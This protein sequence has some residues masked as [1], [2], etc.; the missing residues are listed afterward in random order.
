MIINFY[1][2]HFNR[3]LNFVGC[4]SGS[5][6]LCWKPK[7]KTLIQRWNGAILHRKIFSKREPKK[8]FNMFFDPNEFKNNMTH[9]NMFYVQQDR[10]AI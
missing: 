5:W 10:D 9:N 8:F 2:F 6:I 4:L 7:Y 1:S 3:R